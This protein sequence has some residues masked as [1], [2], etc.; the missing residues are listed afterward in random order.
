M[1][2]VL[3]IIKGLK[4]VTCRY[5]AVPAKPEPPPLH[6]LAIVPPTTDYDTRFS[7]PRCYQHLCR[8]RRPG[9]GLILSG[10]AGSHCWRGGCLTDCFPSLP[11]VWMYLKNKRNIK[12]KYN[13]KALRII[14]WHM[15]TIDKTVVFICNSLLLLWIFFNKVLKS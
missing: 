15:S 8:R 13:N 4:D 12:Y 10:P 11:L 3:W 5:S 2:N 9:S 1:I 6:D 14:F 7:S